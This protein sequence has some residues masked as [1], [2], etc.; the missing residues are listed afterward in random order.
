[1]WFGTQAGVS[2]LAIDGTWSTY[3]VADGLAADVINSIVVG[4]DGSLWFGT[5]GAGVSRYKQAE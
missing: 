4:L 2:R 3:T 5:G 1:M